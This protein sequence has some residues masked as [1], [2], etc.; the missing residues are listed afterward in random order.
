ME[1]PVGLAQ[2]WSGG[3]IYI[4]PFLFVLTIIVFFHELGHFLVGRWCGI[5]A[6][7]FSVGFGPE[8]IGFNDRRGTRWKLAAVPLGGYVKFLGDENAASVPDRAAVDAMSDAERSGAFPAKSVGR[9]AA[10]VAA[11]PIANFILAIVIFA[12]VAYVEGRVVGDPVVAEVRDGSPAAAAGFKP[13]DKVLSADGET[14]RYFSDLQRYVSS[15]ADTPIRMTV[16][17]NGSPVELTVT[18]RSEVQ[19]DGFGN[20]FKVPVV[21]LVANN[22]GSSF[23]VE[24]LSPVEA[25]AYGVSQTWFVTTR[26]VDFMGEVITGRQNAD[27]IGGPIRI[28]QVSSQVSTIGLG[29]LLNLAALLSVSIG[30]LNLLPIPMLDGGH[31]LFYA[32][33]A[34]RGR[35]LSEQVQEVGFRIGLALV[36]LLMVFAFWNDISGLV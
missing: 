36:M 29:A 5:K 21:G 30:L 28:A 11:G 25:V 32:F 2:I 10:T 24:S 3:L 13:G 15:R 23:R 8:L 18:P 16:E 19:T 22:D 4:V 20:E 7:V 27:Q 31:L 33:E 35:P 14:I 6:L 12:G 34:I 26:T 9:R 17:R 1:S